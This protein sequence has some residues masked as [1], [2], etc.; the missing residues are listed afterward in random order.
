MDSKYKS[1]YTPPDTI[2]AGYHHV[3]GTQK[4]WDVKPIGSQT[5]QRV[6]K[7]IRADLVPQVEDENNTSGPTLSGNTIDHIAIDSLK[8]HYNECKNDMEPLQ[9]EAFKIVLRYYGVSL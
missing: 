5:W 1:E 4:V 8:W 3:Y 7:Y 6:A 2:W 9:K